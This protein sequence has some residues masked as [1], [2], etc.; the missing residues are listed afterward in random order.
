MSKFAGNNLI[1]E[2]RRSKLVFETFFLWHEYLGMPDLSRFLSIES[3]CSGNMQISTLNIT[4][5]NDIHSLASKES[6]LGQIPCM[7]VLERV[8]VLR[9]VGVCNQKTIMSLSKFP[10]LISFYIGYLPPLIKID[11]MTS[12]LSC[13][14]TLRYI[15]IE[16]C[17]VPE[18]DL[19]CCD[20]LT[21]LRL[22]NAISLK[23]LQISTLARLTYMEISNSRMQASN[24]MAIIHAQAP[25]LQQVVVEANQQ[26]SGQVVFP[27]M[28]TLIRLNI[29][30]C[31]HIS[32]LHIMNACRLESLELTCCFGLMSLVISSTTPHLSS[33]NV[34]MLQNLTEL[35]I[36]ATCQVFSDG[37]GLAA[38]LSSAEV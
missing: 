28:P 23:V 8:R 35:K 3:R 4:D 17:L 25:Y 12:R 6:I 38:A 32:S 24:L 20:E 9:Y 2:S 27:Q 1:T 26:L 10:K 30:N 31:L 34:Q 33:L 13:I 29:S 36:P 22:P 11:V 21:Q 19:S 16:K 37:S 18:I 15:H 7:S 14:P 5:S